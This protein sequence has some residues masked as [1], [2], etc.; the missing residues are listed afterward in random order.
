MNLVDQQ[1]TIVS[2]TD[3]EFWNFFETHKEDLHRLLR[4][5]RFPED[6]ILDNGSKMAGEVIVPNRKPNMIQILGSIQML[7][8]LL[9]IQL[10]L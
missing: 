3:S 9:R 4:G 7:D 5:L 2:F 10:F 1:W 6:C 8:I